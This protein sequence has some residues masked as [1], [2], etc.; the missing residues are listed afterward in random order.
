MK[1]D[2]MKILGRILILLRFIWRIL[3]FALVQYLFFS[4]VKFF[5]YSFSCPM[6]EHFALGYPGLQDLDF[7]KNKEGP[8]KRQDDKS[9]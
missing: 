8:I 9:Y 6:E 4:F 7:G 2:R 5:P 1:T 3:S